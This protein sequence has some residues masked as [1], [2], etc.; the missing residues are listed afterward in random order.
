MNNVKI[1]KKINEKLPNVV[2][3]FDIFDI[4]KILN[5]NLVKSK[6]LNNNQ[7]YFLKALLNS[8]KSIEKLELIYKHFSDFNSKETKTKIFTLKFKEKLKNYKE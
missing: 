1:V 3:I 4:K 6:V 7:V 5:N 8:L 2:D